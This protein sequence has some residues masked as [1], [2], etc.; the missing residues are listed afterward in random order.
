LLAVPLA[1]RKWQVPVWVPA[2]P[3]IMLGLF[4]LGYL[5]FQ[6]VIDYYLR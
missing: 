2:V 4:D 1:F 6:L 5:P 3:A